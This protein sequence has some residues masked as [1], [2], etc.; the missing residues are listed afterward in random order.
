MESL[1][2]AVGGSEDNCQ[3]GNGPHCQGDGCQD[4]ESSVLSVSHN[5]RNPLGAEGGLETE[6]ALILELH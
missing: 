1:R 5:A 3:E 6:V 2:V 4:W